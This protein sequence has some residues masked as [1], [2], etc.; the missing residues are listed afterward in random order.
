MRACWLALCAG[1]QHHCQGRGA[2]RRGAALR[3]PRRTA[4][5]HYRRAAARRRC[6]R[7]SPCGRCNWTQTRSRTTVRR[8]AP[9]CPC[10]A[11]GARHCSNP[12][13]V[14]AIAAVLRG[15]S[16]RGS[17]ARCK[18]CTLADRS[19]ARAAP[20]QVLTLSDNGITDEGA[21]AFAAA[22]KAVAGPCDRVHM[23]ADVS[24]WLPPCAAAKLPFP[25]IKLSKNGIKCAADARRLRRRRR[26]S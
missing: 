14:A 20:P 4:G 13:G 9:R 18:H 1:E 6:R 7:T 22:L 21:A 24:V 23:A 16:A 25:A 26:I 2:P 5:A 10:R 8:C 17:G 11:Y 12:T 3:N 19:V 15:P